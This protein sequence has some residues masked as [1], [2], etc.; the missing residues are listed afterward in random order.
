MYRVINFRK[1][2]IKCN[3]LCPVERGIVTFT[4]S[5]T[6]FFTFLTTNGWAGTFVTVWIDVAFVYFSCCSEVPIRKL[7]NMHFECT[8]IIIEIEVHVKLTWF[9]F[10]K[11]NKKHWFFSVCSCMDWIPFARRLAFIIRYFLFTEWNYIAVTH[12]LDVL[13]YNH[14]I[15]SVHFFDETEKKIFSLH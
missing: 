4:D 9:K 3:C 7:N 6:F 11:S 2:K 10:S 8:T 1:S 15:T 5:Q 14:T 13:I 12:E